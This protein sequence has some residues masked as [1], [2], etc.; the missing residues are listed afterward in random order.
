MVLYQTLAKPN[1]RPATARGGV[2][3]P[4]TH[5]EFNPRS[6]QPSA[7]HIGPGHQ[8]HKFTNHLNSCTVLAATSRGLN[9]GALG[10]SG[11]ESPVKLL[12]NEKANFCAIS[13]EK[14]SFYPIF[15]TF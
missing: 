7:H 8:K 10:Q 3:T 15:N 11:K 12:Y 6:L 1:I 13:S 4:G 9:G 2:Y 14:L 5:L